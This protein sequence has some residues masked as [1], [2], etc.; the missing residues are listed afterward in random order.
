MTYLNDDCRRS[1]RQDFKKF[2]ALI[3]TPGNLVTGVSLPAN[4]QIYVSTSTLLASS[5]TILV[6]AGTRALGVSSGPANATH[7]VGKLSRAVNVVKA[8][9]APGTVKLY[10]RNGLGK[11]FLIAQG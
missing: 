5:P 8:A 6:N 1:D 4:G 7:H 11:L 2:A 9:G 3:K 10:V